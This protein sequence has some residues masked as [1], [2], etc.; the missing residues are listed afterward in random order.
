MQ[1]KLTPEQESFVKLANDQGFTTEI[2]PPRPQPPT[3]DVLDKRG[4]AAALKIYSS[5]YTLTLV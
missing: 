5:D 3:S 4:L 1:N 2:T